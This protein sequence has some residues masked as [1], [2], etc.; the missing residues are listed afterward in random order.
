MQITRTREKPA[1]FLQSMSLCSASFATAK[2][3]VSA[4]YKFTEFKA[5]KVKEM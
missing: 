1:I 4:G 5:Q 2:F 3:T